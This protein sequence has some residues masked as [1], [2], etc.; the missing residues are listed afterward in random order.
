MKKNKSKKPKKQKPDVET[1]ALPPPT[2]PIKPPGNE[3]P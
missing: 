2:P 1:A 3:K